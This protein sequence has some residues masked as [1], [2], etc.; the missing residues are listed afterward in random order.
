[1]GQ[2]FTERLRD[3]LNTYPEDIRHTVPILFSAHSLPMQIVSGRGDPYPAEVA[4]TVAAVMTKL[5]WSNPYRVTWQSQVGPSAWLGPQ[6][7]DSVKG[8]AKQG[9]QHQEGRARASLLT[10]L[11]MHR[12]QARCGCADCLHARSCVLGPK[13]SSSRVLM[14]NATADIE[15]LYELD[16]ELVEEAA[17]VR[18][19]LPLA[20]RSRH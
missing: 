3:V 12:T 15:T 11:A 4:A 9:E 10:S 2:A 16:Q 17:E 7:S 8:W 13:L 18:C 1:V 14:S 20:L 19:H 6:T 5:G